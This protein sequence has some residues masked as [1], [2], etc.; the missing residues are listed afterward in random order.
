MDAKAGILTGLTVIAAVVIMY[1]IKAQT[2]ANTLP[3]LAEHT[4]L[5]VMVRNEAAVIE[6]LLKSAKGEL[7]S[8]LV[9]CDTGSTDDTLVIAASTWGREGLSIHVLPPFVNFEATFKSSP[10]WTP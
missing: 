7:A 6:R 5:V 2:Q 3:S 1:F 9:I 4:V 10:I 8:H